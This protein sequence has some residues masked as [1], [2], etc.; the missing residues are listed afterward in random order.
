MVTEA[1]CSSLSGDE[2]KRQ[3]FCVPNR[4]GPIPEVQWE[5]TCTVIKISAMRQANVPVP[6]VLEFCI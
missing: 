2:R 4:D 6:S 1:V 3:S 5:G